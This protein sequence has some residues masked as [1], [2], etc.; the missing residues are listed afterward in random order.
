MRDRIILLN[1]LRVI[2]ILEKDKVTLIMI[3]RDKII[4]PTRTTISPILNLN[5]STTLSHTIEIMEAIRHRLQQLITTITRVEEIAQMDSLVIVLK[6]LLVIKEVVIQTII[7]RI[8]MHL[9]DHIVTLLMV[10]IAM[11]VEA[12]P[13][14]NS[15]T[16][17]LLLLLTILV[18]YKCCKN[19]KLTPIIHLTL[20]TELIARVL[21]PIKL[22]VTP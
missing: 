13:I 20:K 16:L 7:D 5:S 11:V 12:N 3:L 18:N 8:M 22:Q 1:L 2:T 15:L 10:H 21:N 9:Q 17:H 6:Y 4:Q 19:Y 14:I